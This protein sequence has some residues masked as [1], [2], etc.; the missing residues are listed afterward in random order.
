M[1]T[2]SESPLSFRSD[3]D[4]PLSLQLFSFLPASDKFL[5]SRLLKAKYIKLWLKCVLLIVEGKSVLCY[6]W[7]LPCI[8]HYSSDVLHLKTVVSFPATYFK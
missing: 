4:L 8:L 3:E 2:N 6:G 7:S 5:T 1:E